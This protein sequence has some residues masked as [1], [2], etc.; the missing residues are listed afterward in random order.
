[1]GNLC[2]KQSKDDNNF[3]GSGR[4]LGSAPP[5]NDNAKASIPSQA[6]LTATTPGRTLGGS[7]A[8][9]AESGGSDSSDPR[10]AAAKA[11]EARATKSP[12]P[13]KLSQQ[14]DAQR[15]QTQ[16]QALKQVADENRMARDADRNTAVRNYN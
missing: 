8:G 11:A 4:V 3:Q 13:D 1:M 6:K 2:G 7:G 9:G 16:Q 15:R 5:R 10:S 12:A 14:L